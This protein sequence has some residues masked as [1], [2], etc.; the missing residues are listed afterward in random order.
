MR[1]LEKP[2]PGTE[3]RRI[4]SGGMARGSPGRGS[5]LLDV[6]GGTLELACSEI[7]TAL[8]SSSSWSF[9]RSSWS[10]LLGW[11]GS[12]QVGTH[13]SAFFRLCLGSVSLHMPDS[14]CFQSP[15]RVG[16]SVSTTLTGLRPTCA[17]RRK[18]RPTSNLEVEPS[19]LPRRPGM[20]TLTSPARRDIGT[21]RAVPTT[22]GPRPT[23]RLSL[24][25]RNRSA[26]LKSHHT[27]GFTYFPVRHRRACAPAGLL[28]HL[29]EFL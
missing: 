3:L 21:G 26:V 9:C 25:P 8:K 1:Y 23:T 28:Q 22:D 11:S 15:G 10:G 6:G 29:G 14:S 12:L 13:S 2:K 4:R 7:S 27:N 24:L 20:T 19:S 5:R 17:T 18:P 16:I